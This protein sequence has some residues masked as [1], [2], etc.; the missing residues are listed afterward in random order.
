MAFPKILL[1]V[2]L[3]SCGLLIAPAP[4]AEIALVP[5]EAD[6]AHN[7]VGQ[8]VDLPFV[9]LHQVLKGGHIT[10]ADSIDQVLF[11][12]FHHFFTLLD[13]TLTPLVYIK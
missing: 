1:T 9:S 11:I 13:E 5:I 8:V 6:G 4:G 3:L 2:T 10:T 7:I 12:V